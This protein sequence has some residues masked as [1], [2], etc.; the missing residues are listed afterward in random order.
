MINEA[1]AAD[2]GGS[3]ASTTSEQHT[4]PGEGDGIA[5]HGDAVD[6]PDYSDVGD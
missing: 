2:E 4:G 3:G 1:D 5:V 6:S